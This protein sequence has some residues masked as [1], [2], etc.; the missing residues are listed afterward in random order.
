VTAGP[1]AEL[2][3]RQAAVWGLAPFE[4]IS[5][6]M[7]DIHERLVA[8][9]GPRPGERWL[10]VAT[11]TGPVACRA[12]RAGAH[13]TGLDLAPALL[14]TARRLAAADGLAIAFDVGD[15]EALPYPDASFDVVASA[16]GAIFAPD[17]AAVARELARVCRPGGR[18]GL[19]AWDPEGGAARMTRLTASFAPA[20]P[21]GAGN[22]L[23][24][25]REAYAARRL[26]GAF[27]LEFERGVSVHTEPSAEAMW[28]LFLAAAGP[29]KAIHGALE[30]ARREEL[31]RAF[32]GLVD[33]HREGDAV[34]FPRQYLLVVG[35][36]RRD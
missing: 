11:G 18:L 26:G 24:W 10:D 7:A 31:H 21:P 28:H 6:T 23:D 5:D 34:R 19:V 8:R 36:R 9:L 15:C 14:E 12:A 4:R 22:A 32:V 3:R 17:H 2:K 13:V 16:L 20:P 25:G 29:V 35:R 1:F 30:P 27:A 33:A